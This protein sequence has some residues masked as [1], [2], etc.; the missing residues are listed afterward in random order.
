VGTKVESSSDLKSYNVKCFLEKPDLKNA[1]QYVSSGD[2]LWNSGIFVFKLSVLWESIQRFAPEIFNSLKEIEK[3]M[4]SSSSEEE[5][6]RIYSSING[7]SFD[8]AIMEKSDSIYV[9]KGD[10]SWNDLGSWKQIYE[11]ARKDEFENASDGEAIFEET[12]RS[13]AY[14]KDAIIA[15]LAVKDLL[16]IQEGNATLVCRRGKDEEIKK[17]VERMKS[18]DMEK[19]L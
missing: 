2:Y 8:Y 6:N 14:S 17:L 7:I 16:V 10:F 11:M 9:I 4:K 18:R 15:L 13:F 3:I 1:S 5:I 19:Y 12:E